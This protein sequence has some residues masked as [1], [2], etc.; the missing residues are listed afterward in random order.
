MFTSGSTHTGSCYIKKG[1]QRYVKIRAGNTITWPANVTFDLD[2]GVVDT[3]AKGT[4]TIQEVGNGWYRCAVTATAGATSNTNLN[5]YILND[6]KSVS[7]TGTGTETII[8]WGA[9]V[10][11]GATPSSFIPSDDGTSTVSGEAESFTIPSAN[12]PWPTPQLSL[13]HI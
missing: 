8:V 1:T 9:Q 5:I 6:S 11:V 2:D 12:L 7:F 10:E 13:I 3:E 4:G